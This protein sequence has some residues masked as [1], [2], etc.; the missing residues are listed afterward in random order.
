MN[1]YLF[2]SEEELK[3]RI[4]DAMKDFGYLYEFGRT[5]LHVY[6]TNMETNGV[7]SFILTHPYRTREDI[8]RIN[9]KNL[10]NLR[11]EIKQLMLLSKLE[12]RYGVL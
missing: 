3:S 1:E 5:M 7:H 8:S 10:D 11:E 9:K 6:V 4:R 12:D 2:R